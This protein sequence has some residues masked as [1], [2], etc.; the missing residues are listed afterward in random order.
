[1]DGGMG[2]GLPVPTVGLPMLFVALLMVST[3][4]YWSFKEM[5]RL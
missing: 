2:S 5:A 1:M 4:R 3:F